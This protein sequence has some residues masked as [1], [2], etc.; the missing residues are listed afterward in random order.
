MEISTKSERF[1]KF[2]TLCSPD[3]QHRKI[4]YVFVDRSPV[5]H[6]DINN[7]AERKIAM[8][9]LVERGLCNIQ[10]AGELCGF[11]RNTA[12]KIL[13][14]KKLLGI[15]A[16]LS[17]GRG[18]K[19]PYKYID[20]VRSH[21]E[22]LLCEHP[23]WKD[24]DV[25]EQAS[26]D[27]EMSISRSAVARIRTGEEEKPPIPTKA[28]L[29]DM[30]K[31]AEAFEKEHMEQRQ[32]W[33]NF[34]T[35]PELKHLAEECSKEPPP[36]AKN[37]TQQ[38]FI[39]RLQQGMKCSFAGGLMH[40]LFMQEIGFEE[41]MAPFPLHP[42]ASYQSLDIMTTIF[43]SI[44]HGLPSIETLKLVNSNEFGLLIGRS[45]IPD[46]KTLRE[47]LGRMAEQHLSGSLIDAFARALL[48]QERIDREVFFID[49]HFLPYYGL[50]VIA[51]G[52]F[53]VRRL[54]MKGNELYAITDLQGRP[55]FF[56]TESNE[57]DF[58]P[59]IARSAEML[60][61]FGIDRPILV[62]DRGGYGIHFFKELDPIA[63]FVTWAKYLNEKSL[64]NLP[65]TLFSV[66]VF[67]GDNRFMVAE[68]KR[69][70][71]ESIQT[72]TKDGR[73]TP[74]S[75]ELRLV[76]LKAPNTGKCLGVYT[77]NTSK[78]AHD[79]AY[80]MLQRWGKSENVYKELMATFNL[81]YHPGYDI[82]ELEQQPLV[83]NP[84]IALIQKAIK[85]LKKE[86]HAI[87]NEILIT[88]A[89]LTKRQDQRL[90]KKLSNLE[91]SLEEKKNDIDQFQQKISTLPDKVSIIDVLNGRPLSRC[92][93]EKKKLYDLMQFMV[94]HSQERLLE[95][96]QDYYDDHR[97][98]KKVLQMITRRS[99][100]VKL[101]GQTLI[102]MIEWIE[103][104]KHRLAAKRLCRKL[105]HLKI[106]MVGPLNLALSFQVVRFP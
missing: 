63:D 69:M 73:N 43:H 2:F 64:K 53:T 41:L 39:E 79:I 75:I 98:I 1:E 72:A 16:V 99:G 7:A 25:A 71:T 104:R 97:D 89:K 26:K 6:F 12:G 15:E 9:Q 31:E 77:N 65:D 87:E 74:S 47:H 86:D 101:V 28:E 88:Q 23:E 36:R 29:F 56:I 24:Q 59:I 48:D 92:D 102:V 76:V 33:L 37:D 95:L 96:F 22:D 83:S 58:R 45:R 30:A 62:F 14:T 106:K 8:I 27:L 82:K 91:M 67:C 55:L 70:V 42:G 35:E 84:E 44:A 94:Y 13:Q 21:I 54:A 78:P 19:K 81:N 46:K 93:L 32:L 4:K 80:Y 49:G 50:N 52:Y 5:I 68:E 34:D 61:D 11:H 18:L 57:I 60:V 100:L 20:E 85:V 10:T 105:N 3:D 103:N 40:H 66:G 90:L 38:S 51:K 17:D